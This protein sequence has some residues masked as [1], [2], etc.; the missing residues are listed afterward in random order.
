MKKPLFL[1]LLA[2]TLFSL[3]PLS[4]QAHEKAPDTEALLDSLPDEYA[5]YFLNEKGEPTLPGIAAFLNLSI[6][7]LSKA[8][9]DSVVHLKGSVA[10]ILLSGIFAVFEQSVKGERSKGILHLCIVLSGILSISVAII[11]L[12]SLAEEHLNTLCG[13][14]T[15]IFPMINGIQLSMGAV[16]S[17]SLT[18][19][20]LTLLL[21]LIGEFS[22]GMLLP[23]QKLCFAFDLTACV[24]QNKG[25][26]SF[27]ASIKKTFLF[28]LGGLSAFLMA[29]FTFQNVVAAKADS[30][31]IR[32]FRFTAGGLVPVVG[33][34]LSES[35]RILL[36]GLEL[37]KSTVGG[38]GIAVMLLMLLAPLCTLFS[39]S[40]C[41]NVAAS[42]AKSVEC[43]TLSS[44]FSSAVSTL[45]CMCGIIILCDL[46]ALFT[47]SI[48]L[49]QSI[50]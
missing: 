45:N 10:L 28:L 3:F 40:F 4:L 43:E 41:F 34:A 29:C 48:T 1:L 39:S 42:V 7:E 35:S 25:L 30:A 11:D 33:S 14:I 5:D 38:I 2:A 15:C 6:K 18:V 47:V 8:L 23:L 31:T 13:F 17:A 36:A 26:L 19:A 20:S 37:L 27:A 46:S 24:T 16:G 50:Q 49:S 44:L 21:S 32:A 12:F 9:K 22:C